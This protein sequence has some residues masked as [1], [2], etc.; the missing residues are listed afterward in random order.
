MKE[1]SFKY[2][3]LVDWRK[4]VEYSYPDIRDWYASFDMTSNF[5]LIENNVYLNNERIYSF[6][7][8]NHTIFKKYLIEKRFNDELKEVL[9]V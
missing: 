4:E 5:I 6:N 7:H 1:I 3:E 9:S 8:D 2:Q